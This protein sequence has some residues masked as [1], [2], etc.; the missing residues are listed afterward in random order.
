MVQFQKIRA[1]MASTNTR[2]LLSAEEITRQLRTL[3]YS[4][5]NRAR[6]R[7]GRKEPLKRIAEQAGVHRATLYR[8]IWG[9]RISDKSREA[10]SL[11]LMSESSPH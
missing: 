9:G 6:V 5:D 11:V 3:R 10:L 7:G 1:S 8:I 4:P 2:R